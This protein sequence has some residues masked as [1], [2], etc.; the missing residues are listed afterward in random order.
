MLK[1]TICFSG[2]ISFLSEYGPTDKEEKKSDSLQVCPFHLIVNK[3]L[4]PM[5][6]NFGS[7]ISLIIRK[8]NFL[9]KNFIG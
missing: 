5:P 2:K 3:Q 4:K 7:D 1:E 9:A 8:L 6:K